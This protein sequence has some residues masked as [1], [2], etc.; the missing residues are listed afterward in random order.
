MKRGEEGDWD[1]DFTAQSEIRLVAH[2]ATVV[3]FFST[4]VDNRRILFGDRAAVARRPRSIPTPAFQTDRHPMQGEHF[5]RPD[6]LSGERKRHERQPGISRSAEYGNLSKLQKRDVNNASY[7][8]S[9]RR[10]L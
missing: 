1:G 2:P 4:L 6:I 10:G 7:A 5:A 8:D 9:R 3:T